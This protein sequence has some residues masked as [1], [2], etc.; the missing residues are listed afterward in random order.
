MIPGGEFGRPAPDT[1]V[2]ILSSVTAPDGV[3]N[4]IS[5]IC[6]TGNC[7]F[8]D[9]NSAVREPQYVMDDDSTTHSTVTMC[10]TCVDI[11]SLVSIKNNVSLGSKSIGVRLYTLPNHF[12]VSCSP[13]GS[14]T[15]IIRPAKDLAWMGD[16]L[17]SELKA[18]SRWAYVNA[19][20]LSVG[21]NSST[22]IAATCILYP[23][24]RTY[25]ASIT[26]N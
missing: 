7:T 19:T 21:S 1:V 2:A 17:T 15:A 13:S 5:G 10:D 26:R 18:K 6:S 23:C 9:E 25:N 8:R 22:A 14:D 12:N 20:F 24:L 16:L 4:R 3:E 11:A